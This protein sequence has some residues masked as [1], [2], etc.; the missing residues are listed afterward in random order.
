MEIE[1]KT[2]T[3]KD[4]LEFD[5]SMKYYKVVLEMVGK[6]FFS[7]VVFK[8]FYVVDDLKNF[9]DSI[10]SILPKTKEEQHYY[11]N[12]FVD[13]DDGDVKTFLVQEI[14]RRTNLNVNVK[15]LRA[16]EYSGFNLFVNYPSTKEE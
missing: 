3:K 4:N 9:V 16:G 15:N 13:C 12:I 10:I 14:V 11:K 5:P 8:G 6:Q 7:G 1:S 2:N